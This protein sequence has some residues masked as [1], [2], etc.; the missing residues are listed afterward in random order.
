MLDVLSQDSKLAFLL[1]GH[2][3]DKLL[4]LVLV[5]KF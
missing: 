3:K 2:K 4:K 5:F 1:V